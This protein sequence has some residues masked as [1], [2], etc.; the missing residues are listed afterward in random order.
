MKTYFRNQWPLGWTPNASFIGGNPDGLATMTNL[1]QDATGAISLVYGSRIISSGAFTH[2]PLK[3]Y[4]KFI[5]LNSVLNSP[6]GYPSGRVPVRYVLDGRNIV[7][8]FSSARKSETFFDQ[9][10]ITNANTE[11]GVA[12]GFGSGH[13]FICAGSEKWKD[14]GVTQTRLGMNGPPAPGVGV[15]PSPYID[16]VSNPSNYQE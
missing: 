3:I 12:F 6:G 16:L 9:G 10:V 8:N 7:R 4:L 14:T 15:N 2:G 11:Q 5:D 1:T 13:V